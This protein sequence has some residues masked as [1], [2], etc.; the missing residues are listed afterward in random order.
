M[1]RKN[2]VKWYR[3]VF[4]WKE[5]KVGRYLLVRE[6]IERDFVNVR[7]INNIDCGIWDKSIVSKNWNGY[8]KYSWLL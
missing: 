6:K 2:K 5:V 8:V 7:K 4:D 1:N 3:G